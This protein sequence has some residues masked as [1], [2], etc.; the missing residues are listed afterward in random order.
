MQNEAQH[1]LDRKA[2]KISASSSHNL[3]KY[4]YFTD[5]DVG[6]K[7]STV[8]QAKFEYSPLD[9]SLSKAFKNDEVKSVASC[10]KDFNYDSNHA[11]SNFTKGM[12]ILPRFLDSKYNKMK[13]F[14]KLLISFKSV[15][16]KKTEAK[17]KKERIMK[18]V[19]EL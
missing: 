18:N 19:D 7:P 6:L 13:G 10:K 14:N 15:K 16:T 5:E 11:F 12:M 17:L 2:A 4:E 3:D 8:A 1:D 9:M